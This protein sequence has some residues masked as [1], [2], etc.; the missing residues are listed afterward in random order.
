MLAH[1]RRAHAG[2]SLVEAALALGLLV[3]MAAGVAHLVGL[4]T[5]AVSQAHHDTAMVV[6][7]VDKLEQLRS[8]AWQFDVAD[9]TPVSDVT[10]DLAAEALSTGGLG[11]TA[12][13]S[14]SL[15]VSTP[16]FVDYLDGSGRWRGTGPEP[17]A[18]TVYIRRWAIT[19]L[20]AD[21]GHSLALQVAV[22]TLAEEVRRRPASG[23]GVPPAVLL[24]TLRTRR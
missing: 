21:V 2:F 23:R 12:S 14:D 11:L 4:A 15:W 19:P 13:P 7:A 18:G 8:L 3:T 24:S 1:H 9:G 17:A 6:L 16:G 22:T 10:T 5:R 20:D